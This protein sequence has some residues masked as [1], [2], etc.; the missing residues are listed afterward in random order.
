[1]SA[2]LFGPSGP[3]W[4]QART[5][6]P[7]A[8]HQPTCVGAHVALQQP[9]P[10]EGL[11]ADGA[12]AGQRVGAQVHLEGAQA[13]VLLVAVSAGEA[14]ACPRLAVQ[15]PVPGQPSRRVV[16]LAA[17]HALEAAGGPGR[18]QP[19]ICGGVPGGARDRG[20]PCGQQQQRGQVELVQAIF[21]GY[22]GGPAGPKVHRA[23]VQGVWPGG[24]PHFLVAGKGQGDAGDDRVAL[25]GPGRGSR[26]GRGRLIWEEDGHHQ[27]PAG[28]TGTIDFWKGGRRE[29]VQVNMSPHTLS[30]DLPCLVRPQASSRSSPFSSQGKD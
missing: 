23:D 29:K 4:G 30:S 27:A 22:A 8:S 1:M 9:G 13:A 21:E 2:H 11:A 28:R 18:T 6:P 17:V 15:L 20:P 12:G 3:V 10:G 26:C 16:G 14:A 19:A 5:L 7:G 25:P 24:P